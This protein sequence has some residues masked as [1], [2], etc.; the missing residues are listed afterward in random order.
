MGPHSVGW[1]SFAMRNLPG[2]LNRQWRD[3]LTKDFEERWF[4]VH[5]Y[6][7]EQDWALQGSY[8]IW[9]GKLTRIVFKE[10]D[11]GDCVCFLVD[12]VK[13]AETGESIVIWTLTR[14]RSIGEMAVIH[15][16]P[17]SAM[18]KA[19]TKSNLL[20]LSRDNFNYMV[21][22]HSSVDDKILKGIVSLLSMNLRKT[23]SRLADY[24]L[25]LG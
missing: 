18:V 12:G 1:R 8:G 10:G 5:Q 2:S 13:E 16:L 6:K 24:M 21:E 20:T 22:G 7:N 19:R 17:Q 4:C 23:S 11:K 25:P 3:W 14:A 15:E 9:I